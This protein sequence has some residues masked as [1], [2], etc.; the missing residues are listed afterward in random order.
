MPGS[1]LLSSSTLMQP[2]FGGEIKVKNLSHDFLQLV[3]GN[4]RTPANQTTITW[5]FRYKM[6]TLMPLVQESSPSQQEHPEQAGAVLG[7]AQLN[8]EMDFTSIICIK[9]MKYS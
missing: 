5:R 1:V 8:L 3:C 4:V 9:L 6:K 7:Q 2:T